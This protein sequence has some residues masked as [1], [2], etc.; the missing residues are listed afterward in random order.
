MAGSYDASTHF[1]ASAESIAQGRQHTAQ[2]A[3]G[4]YMVDS[5]LRAPNA[6]SG[7]AFIDKNI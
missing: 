1:T 2:P 5:K 6:C 3:H 4:E 7:E